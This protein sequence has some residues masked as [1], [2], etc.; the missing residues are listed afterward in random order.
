MPSVGSFNLQWFHKKSAPESPRRETVALSSESPW[1]PLVLP[2]TSP[3]VF[4]TPQPVRGKGMGSGRDTT[5]SMVHKPSGSQL[6]W[7]RFW[8]GQELAQGH[9]RSQGR[10]QLRSQGCALL[11]TF[12]PSCCGGCSRMPVTA[13]TIW[14]TKCLEGIL[15]NG[16]LIINAYIFS[17]PHAKSLFSIL[18]SR[19]NIPLKLV[20]LPL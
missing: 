11:T 3:P 13:A 15:Q 20:T 2:S 12:P 5:N 19:L 7:S 14:L 17:W 10:A 9:R 6:R 16:L 4:T 18:F 8:G 1:P